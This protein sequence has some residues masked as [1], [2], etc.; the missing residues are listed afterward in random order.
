MAHP[1]QRPQDSKIFCIGFNRTGTTS[2][3]TLFQREGFRSYHGTAWR[4]M[5]EA[6][7]VRYDC[8][9][10][11]RPDDFRELDRRYPRSQFILNVRDLDTW[12]R[13]RLDHIQCRKAARKWKREGDYWDDTDAAVR[14]WVVER[15]AY[16]CCVLDYFRDSSQKL[17][18]VNFPGD[19]RA[20]EKIY[21]FLRLPD[22][23]PRRP[24]EN[25]SPAGGGFTRNR[26]RLTRVLREL[27][28]PTAEHQNDILCE[29]LLSEHKK[30]LYPADTSLLET[31]V[32]L[33]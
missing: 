22:P 15:N 13:S 31:C 27:G 33:K 16:H 26:E 8:F 1:R 25:A 24:H 23:P 2:L 14:G 17:L 10:D 3:H 29:S 11:G 4:G 30:K 19:P 9:S 28:I 5:R 32:W 20:V 12:L 21:G 18:I 7:L 6:L